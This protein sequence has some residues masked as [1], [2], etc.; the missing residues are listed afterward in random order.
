M[1]YVRVRTY[2]HIFISDLDVEVAAETVELRIES[3][4]HLENF[5]RLKFLIAFF[6]LNCDFV[7]GGFWGDC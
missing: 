3:L 4:Q 1:V 7:V 6:L 2:F 5:L